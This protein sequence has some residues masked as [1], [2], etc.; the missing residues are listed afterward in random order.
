MATPLTSI[1][2]GPT[3]RRRVTGNRSE[4]LVIASGLSQYAGSAIAVLLFAYIPPAGVAWLRV[5]SAAVAL[6]LWRRPWNSR[7]TK[8]QLRL[9]AGF[10]TAL[11]LMN[12]SFYLAVAR[13]PLGTAAAFE[14]L[15]P[16]VVAGVGSRTKRDVLAVIVAGIGVLLLA[17]VHI[18]GSPSGVGFALAAGLCWAGYIVLG[19][20]V[21]ADTSLRPND[22]LA[23]GMVCGAVALSVLA[24]FSAPAFARPWLLAACVVVGLFSNVVPFALEQLAM[25]RLPRAR[26]ALLLSLLPATATIVGVVLLG[27]VPGLIEIGGIALVVMASALRTHRETPPTT[28]LPGPRRVAGD[29]GL[30]RPLA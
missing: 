10:G 18:A 5:V 14:F 25:T 4:Y 6:S 8:P 30:D 15:G 29:P 9:A 1:E 3:D 16:I 22:G 21:A 12:L 26:F 23:A 27:Q 28:S 24:P 19:H 20:R 11:A 2:R 17:D 7:W 13:L